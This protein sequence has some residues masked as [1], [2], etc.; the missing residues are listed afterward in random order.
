MLGQE[1]PGLFPNYF[2]LQ[3]SNKKMENNYIL[4]HIETFFLKTPFMKDNF[5]KNVLSPSLKS[6]ESLPQL[7]KHILLQYCICIFCIFQS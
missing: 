6:E 1:M 2:N 5:M 4:L 3:N 7:G